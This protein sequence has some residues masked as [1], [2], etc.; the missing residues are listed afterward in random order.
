M[1][2]RF[3]ILLVGTTISTR[4]WKVHINNVLSVVRYMISI[5]GGRLCV[6]LQRQLLVTIGD[7]ESSRDRRVHM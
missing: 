2:C 1:K 4:E 5:A 6:A 3:M 7:D